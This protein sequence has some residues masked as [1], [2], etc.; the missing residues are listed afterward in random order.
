MNR[1]KAF[2]LIFSLL[3][4]L[5]PFFSQAQVT[6]EEIALELDK[7]KTYEYG[8]SRESLTRLSDL[9]RAVNNSEIL[10]EI[11][12]EFVEFLKSNARLPAKQFVCECLSIYGGDVSIPV[13]KD[14]FFKK[15]TTEM[16]LFAIERIPGKESDQVLRDALSKSKG[17]AKVGVINALGNR[18][19]EKS[20]KKIAS[21]LSDADTEIASAA[22]SALGKI[23]G[24]KASNT[25]YNLISDKKNKNRA[26]LI[27]AYLQ[28]AE[29]Y[30]V[31]VNSKKALSIYQKLFKPE[32]V[33]Q[34]RYAALRGIIQNSSQNAAEIIVKNLES[35]D[36]E[37]RS[38]AIRLVRTIPES[39]NIQPIAE[40][41]PGFANEEQV[42]LITALAGR[43]DSATLDAITDATKS[44]DENVRIAALKA[45][46]LSGNSGIVTILA[47]IAANTKGMEKKIA[48][49]SLY[50][51][52]APDVDDEIIKNI[53][54]SKDPVKIELI[55]SVSER[56]IINAAPALMKQLENENQ[57]VRIQAIKALRD[58]ASEENLDQIIEYLVEAKSDQERDE[59]E[60]AVV[61]ATNK[62]PKDQPKATRLIDRLDKIENPLVKSSFYEMLGKIGDPVAL[63]HLRSAL[64]NKDSEI[65]ASAIRALS[66]WPNPEPLDDLLKIAQSSKDERHRV[67]ALRGFVG[68][69]DLDKK[70][71]WDEKTEMYREA[72]NLA[73]NINEKKMV[74]AG[75]S[76]V[77]STEAAKVVVEFLN[78]KNLS[79]EAEMGIVKI[80]QS[81]NNQSV[82]EILPI[83][84]KVNNQTINESTRETS[85]RLINQFEKFEDFIVLWQVSGP[86]TKADVNLFDYAFPPETKEADKVDWQTMPTNLDSINYWHI[87]LVDFFAG[88]NLVAYL[89]N[90]VY[91]ENEK[92][93]LLELGSDDGIK[94][95]LNGELVHSN[96]TMRGVGPGDDKV[97]VKLNKGSNHLLIKVINST[98]GWGACA[99][100]RQP[101]GTK[102]TGIRVSIEQ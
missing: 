6:I 10:K 16:A 85:R 90:Q 18:G 83:L 76:K 30:S 8:A 31:N 7:I 72:I 45:L 2:L 22:I 36:K 52:S 54:V 92:D 19:D 33:Y 62:I 63:P 86:F 73:S 26:K 91:S 41:V 17:R 12:N 53:P 21:L 89:Q 61:T 96:N 100:L 64:K 74:I 94:V 68:L 9:M 80:A 32:N 82:D 101:D 51:L 66:D 98:G 67:L 1:P 93:A 34:V 35:E 99:R 102:L 60:K 39:M 40:T 38:I 24:D 48:S 46:S 29:K 37:S 11:E 71:S 84:R 79:Q 13:L 70:R 75:L 55:R 43:K 69:I 14:M 47:E 42:Q 49:E 65:K 77:H 20:V 95:W 27:D 81:L 5:L 3:I 87:S 50:R 88:D 44:K 4:M 58:V 97:K 78:D 56:R 23:G 57:K 25:L 15:Q 59:L 28:C